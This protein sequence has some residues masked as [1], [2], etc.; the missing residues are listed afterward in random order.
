MFKLP[1]THFLMS[2]QDR[3]VREGLRHNDLI[4]EWTR[5]ERALG[6][7]EAVKAAMALRSAEIEELRHPERALLREMQERMSGR[8][9]IRE[10]RE[11]ATGQTAQKEAAKMLAMNGP[12][13]RQLMTDRM[14]AEASELNVIRQRMQEQ[15]LGYVTF[16]DLIAQAELDRFAS[17]IR[18]VSPAVSGDWALQRAMMLQTPWIDEIAPARSFEA[19]A[20]VSKIA[21]AVEQARSSEPTPSTYL[22]SLV[23]SW[24]P[25]DP[26]AFAVSSAVER[27]RA[28]A[29]SG[30]D[31]RI[32]HLPT[33]AFPEVAR[34]TGLSPPP[35]VRTQRPAD[36]AIVIEASGS[37]SDD[38][39]LQVRS[40]ERM[41][42]HELRKRMPRHF[43]PNWIIGRVPEKMRRGWEER[44]DKSRRGKRIDLL[45]FSYFGDLVQIIMQKGVWETAFMPSIGMSRE[46]FQ[47]AT[48]RLIEIRNV[49]HHAG[50]LEVIEFVWCFSEVTQLRRAFGSLQD[51]EEGED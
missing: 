8:A 20:V 50:E 40:V 27:A 22:R 17:T 2:L 30:I 35:A 7:T 18:S 31:V 19:F 3:A 11:W 42:R 41:L 23:G 4:E 43:G 6:G 44:R 1:E 25:A 15:A 45:D 10:A 21:L 13:A 39:T 37:L 32:S 16:K 24:A 33:A 5:T 46:E 26:V 49:L 36:S 14:I 29:Q 9:A 47:I 28:L 48:N 51:E 34:V 12:T 38:A